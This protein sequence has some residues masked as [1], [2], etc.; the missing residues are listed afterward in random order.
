MKSVENISQHI[1]FLHAH[2][3]QMIF[4]SNPD[5]EFFILTDIAT[6]SIRP[7]FSDSSWEQINIIAHIFEHDVSFYQLIVFWLIDKVLV[8]W[9]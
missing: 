4:L 5:D 2:D 7:V 3:S 6:S 9:G 1:P 8:S